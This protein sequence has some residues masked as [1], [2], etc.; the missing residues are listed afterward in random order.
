[1]D[2]RERTDSARQHFAWLAHP[3]TLA[4]VAVLLVNDHL[5]KHAY[6]GLVTGKLSDVAGLVL[7]PALLASLVTLLAAR[8]PAEPVAVAAVTAVGAGFAVVKAFPE[9]AEVASAAWSVV[10][11][12]SLVRS[13]LTDLLTLPALGVAWLVWTRA[14][15]HPAPGRVA[16]VVRLAVIAPVAL[17]SVMATSAEVITIPYAVGLAQGVDGHAAVLVARFEGDSGAQ[18]HDIVLE[19]R[20]GR[21]WHTPYESLQYATPEQREAAVEKARANRPTACVADGV[22]CWR[23][24]PGQLA[25]EESVDGGVTWTTA[26]SMSGPQRERYRQ[27]V[28]ED[29]RQVRDYPIDRLDRGMACTAVS[30]VRGTGTVVAACGLAGFVSRSESGG[31]TML[32]F[33]GSGLD[34]STSSDWYERIDILI[35]GLLILLAG[36]E[37]HAVRRRRGS[38][39]SSHQTLAVLTALPG[40]LI[41]ASGALDRD[42]TRFVLLFVPYSFVMTAT[43]FGIYLNSRRWFPW[44]TV[45]PAVLGPVAAW[46]IH[47]SIVRGEIDATLGWIR[48]WSV[49]ALALAVS[50]TLGLLT[51]HPQALAE[52]PS[53]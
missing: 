8:A 5:L 45:P 37:V 19:S 14:R 9:A 49:L 38:S 3:I 42:L 31:W 25:I 16:R 24:V 36:G 11:G 44:W 30:V 27:A 33:Y 15:R 41:V 52:S 53:P 39:A 35:A 10:G 47:A 1:M 6:P 7:A 21:S 17:A 34:F 20:D 29:V 48:I 18:R 28:I 4:A 2:G 13:D 12:P 23:V 50:I 32:G 51:R 26:W 40:L 46:V 43:W 22:T